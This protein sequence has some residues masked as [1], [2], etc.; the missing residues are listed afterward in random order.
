MNT[1]MHDLRTPYHEMVPFEWRDEHDV[2]MPKLLA[3]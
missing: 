3:R 1:Y 2:R